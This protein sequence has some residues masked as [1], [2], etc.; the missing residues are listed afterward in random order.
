MQKAEHK[1]VKESASSK[2]NIFNIANPHISADKGAEIFKLKSLIFEQI[3]E[4]LNIKLPTAEL[5]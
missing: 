4:A 1:S 5:T 2:I 3:Q